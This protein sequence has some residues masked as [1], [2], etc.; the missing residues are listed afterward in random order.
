MGSTHRT[1][2]FPDLESI[3]IPLPAIDEQ[4]DALAAANRQLE[5][6]GPL[7]IA[8]NRQVALLRERRQ[9]L[10]TAAVTGKL[11][12]PERHTANAGA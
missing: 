4:G 2:Y 7:E 10:I 5:T 8:L 1:I 11:Q 3:R 9:A 6:L 12:V